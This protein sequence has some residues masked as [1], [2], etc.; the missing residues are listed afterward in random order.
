MPV[1][2]RRERGGIRPANLLNIL[3]SVTGFE[4]ITVALLAGWQEIVDQIKGSPNWPLPIGRFTLQ[5]ACHRVQGL[6]L[7][8]SEPDNQAHSGT[9][10]VA[11]L[12]AELD[13]PREGWW[14]SSYI[15]LKLRYWYLV[16]ITGNLVYLHFCYKHICSIP[17]FSYCMCF[18]L[19]NSVQN[20]T[21]LEDISIIEIV[22]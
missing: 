10:P 3:Q 19:I 6:W 16:F 2:S 21:F 20:E 15:Y 9:I 12:L 5:L 18:I 11:F 17:L 8:G 7:Q 1:T 14:Y 13:R 22:T 4:D